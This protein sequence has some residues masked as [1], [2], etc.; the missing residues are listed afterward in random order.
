MHQTEELKLSKTLPSN[1]VPH[2][3]NQQYY[4]N[5]S[6]KPSGFEVSL[7]SPIHRNQ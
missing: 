4:N 3:Y 6:P 7:P 1:F 2:S 5:S